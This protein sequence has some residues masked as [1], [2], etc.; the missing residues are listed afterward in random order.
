MVLKIA[1]YCTEVRLHAARRDSIQRSKVRDVPNDL[2]SGD[3][4][5]HNALDAAKIE[6]MVELT[7]ISSVSALFL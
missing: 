5:R 7:E 1:I 6:E 3:V 2:R 4:E